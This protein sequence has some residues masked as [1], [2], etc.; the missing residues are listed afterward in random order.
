MLLR[1]VVRG[2]HFTAAGDAGDVSIYDHRGQKL[3][4]C[5]R[6]GAAA[7]AWCARRAG[8]LADRPPSTRQPPQIGRSTVTGY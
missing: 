2:H 3:A 4:G 7:E 5:L 6:N 1:I 8:Q